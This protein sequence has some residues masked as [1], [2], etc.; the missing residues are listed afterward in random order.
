[1]VRSGVPIS[2]EGQLRASVEECP[3]EIHY[4]PVDGEVLEVGVY[5]LK[6]TFIPLDQSI[7]DITHRSV[8]FQVVRKLVPSVDWAIKPI[9]YGESWTQRRFAV[10]RVLFTAISPIIWRWA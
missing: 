4:S 5:H 9:K 3:G 1:M 6:A 8:P 7:H 2:Y 10:L